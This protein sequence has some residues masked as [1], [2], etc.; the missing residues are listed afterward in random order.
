MDVIPVGIRRHL[1]QVLAPGI[2]STITSV[3]T[4]FVD[5]KDSHSGT[6]LL[7]SDEQGNTF[8][9]TAN[10]VVTPKSRMPPRTESAVQ[11]SGKSVRRGNLG[12]VGTGQLMSPIRLRNNF[13]KSERRDLAMLESCLNG[14]EAG[15][16]FRKNYLITSS[17]R[18]SIG[19]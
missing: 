12:P 4:R 6:G 16:S 2:L 5:Q 7:L 8:C 19:K 17:M 18:R 14:F 3:R 11:H 9:F 1:A 15:D 10:H 13:L